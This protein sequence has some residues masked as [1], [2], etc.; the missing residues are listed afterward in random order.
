MTKFGVIVARPAVPKPP[1]IIPAGK[2]A[3]Q[4][5]ADMARRESAK[6]KRTGNVAPR[7]YESPQQ[8]AAPRLDMATER[9]R[10]IEAEISDALE[11]GPIGLTELRGRVRR[12]KDAVR[13]V[14]M[15]M[16]KRGLVWLSKGL[17][18]WPLWALA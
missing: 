1:V 11:G 10:Q 14:L 8:R 6:M 9:H 3:L 18:G 17:K 2:T 12:H 15:D 5:M 16:R 7:H 13:V 4:H